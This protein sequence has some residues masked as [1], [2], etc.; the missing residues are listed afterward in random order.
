MLFV[1][2]PPQ[3]PDAKIV[4]DT[5]HSWPLLVCPL[6]VGVFFFSFWIVRAVLRS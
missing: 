3:M 1:C 6:G 2:M 5:Y 4:S